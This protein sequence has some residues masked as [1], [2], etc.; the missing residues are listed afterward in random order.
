VKNQNKLYAHHPTAM[1]AKN[2]LINDNRRMSP[3][4]LS[5]TKKE[6]SPNMPPNIRHME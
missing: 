1:G 3:E 5:P 2:T 6:S 4:R